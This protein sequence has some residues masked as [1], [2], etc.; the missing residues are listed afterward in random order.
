MA[1]IAA[2]SRP[3]PLLRD[4]IIIG[5]YAKNWNQSFWWLPSQVTPL[6]QCLHPQK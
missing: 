3:R 6:A 4:A 2:I 1:A 5:V